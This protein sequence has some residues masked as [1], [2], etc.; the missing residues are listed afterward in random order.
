MRLLAATAALALAA[1]AAVAASSDWR[2]AETRFGPLE[3]I[4]PDAELPAIGFLRFAGQPVTAPDGG[5]RELYHGH[6]DGVWPVG[7]EDVALIRNGIGGSGPCVFQFLLA[8]A[9]PTGANLTAPFRR[10]G[11]EEMPE[12]RPLGLRFEIAYRTV[13]PRIDHVAVTYENG[14]VTET[15]VPLP[16]APAPLP[17]GGAAVTRWDG[18]YAHE[19]V[20][21]AGERRRFYTIMPKEKLFELMDRLYGSLASVQDGWL[22]AT[23]IMPHQGCNEMGGFAIEIT[24]GRAE[25]AMFHRGRSSELFGGTL[26]TVHPVLQQIARIGSPNCPAQ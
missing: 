17:G 8:V 13:D 23:G 9:T 16:D 24:T 3:I 11:G 10:C 5:E 2:H 19:I 7:A 21:G 26:D 12:V 4:Q 25:A 6:I 1:P 20:R 14:R 22:I 18:V 15:A